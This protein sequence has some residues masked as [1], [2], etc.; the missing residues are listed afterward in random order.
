M[1]PVGFGVSPFTKDHDANKK[2]FEFGKAIGLKYLSADPTPD[3]FDSLDK[4]CDEYKIAIAIHPHGPRA[5][6][7]T[8]GGRP[9]SS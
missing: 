6:G 1:T 8:A 4:L 3:A 5:R 2:F 7:G 9:R